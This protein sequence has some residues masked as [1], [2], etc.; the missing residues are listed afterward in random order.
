MR[1]DLART[2]ECQL[3]PSYTGTLAKDGSKFDSSLDRNEP[4]EFTRECRASFAS[5][6]DISVSLD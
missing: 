2:H 3:I 4:F 1:T 6:H 5:Y